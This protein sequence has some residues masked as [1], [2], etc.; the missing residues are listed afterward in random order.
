MRASWREAEVD[1]Q[2]LVINCAANYE[3]WAE[4]MDVMTGPEKSSLLKFCACSSGTS[5]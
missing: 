3:C 1:A 4:F 5:F 2:T